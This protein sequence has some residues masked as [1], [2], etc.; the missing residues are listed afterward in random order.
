MRS[1]NNSAFRNIRTRRDQTNIAAP[2]VGE[3]RSSVGAW[4]IIG[5]KLRQTRGSHYPLDTSPAG[6]STLPEAVEVVDN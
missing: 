2:K 4:A 6:L 1:G 5:N 3:R